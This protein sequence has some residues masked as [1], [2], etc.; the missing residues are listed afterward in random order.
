MIISAADCRGGETTTPVDNKTAQK[1]TG[2]K[3]CP[4]TFIDTKIREDGGGTRSK[5][6]EYADSLFAAMCS[7]L[8]SPFVM[9]NNNQ[10]RL[11]VTTFTEASNVIYSHLHCLK[12]IVIGRED[13]HLENNIHN[14]KFYLAQQETQ[15]GK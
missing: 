1:S 8:V 12:K 5:T 14:L 13:G 4:Q 10:W 15:S 7:L 3:T 6:K 2:T 11:S 9:I